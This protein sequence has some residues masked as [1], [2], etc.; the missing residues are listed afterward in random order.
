MNLFFGLISLFLPAIVAGVVVIGSAIWVHKDVKRYKAAGVNIMEPW[1]W[2]IL[3][4]LMWLPFFPIYLI[5]KFMK[6]NKQSRSGV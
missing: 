1:A 6:Y 2:S 4:F 3:V 5:L